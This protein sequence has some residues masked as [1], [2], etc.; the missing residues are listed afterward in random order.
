[1]LGALNQKGFTL[2]NVIAALG[3]TTVVLAAIGVMS[4]QITK[5]GKYTEFVDEAND[6][7]KNIERA[8]LDETVCT[9]NLINTQLNL[10]NP[11]PV[12]QLLLMTPT[13]FAATLFLPT[14]VERNIV[15]GDLQL[16]AL[17][18]ITPNHYLARLDM[19]YQ[20]KSSSLFGVKQIARSIV[21]EV[22]T[23]ASLRVQ[24]CSGAGLV[25]SSSTL[26]SA[27]C[28]ADHY[29]TGFDPSGNP[30]CTPYTAPPPPPVPPVD[31]CQGL[32]EGAFCYASIVTVSK[33]CL[34]QSC[35]DFDGN[36]F[37]FECAV[38]NGERYECVGG[39]LVTTSAPTLVRCSSSEYVH[40]TSRAHNCPF[41][42]SVN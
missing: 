17:D 38:E 16:V 11:T 40:A 42:A 37:P 32:A 36:V 31:N 33:T 13:G 1:M 15:H 10:T 3:I 12:N 4:I 30:V 25:T 18:E 27:A 14:T 9:N 7:Y 23:D 22:E 20:Q 8:L 41:Q 24:S 19:F 2:F 28:P 35:T 6:S 34:R 5:M 26:A 29:V 21:I 39:N